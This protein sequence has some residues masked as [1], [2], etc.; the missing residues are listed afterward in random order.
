MTTVLSKVR[1]LRAHDY[2]V[3]L[4]N[5]KVKA[6]FEGRYMV[7]DP[8]DSIDEGYAIVGNNLKEIVIEAHDHLLWAVTNG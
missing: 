8:L 1:E 5:P 7:F 4:R 6:E 2:F 3:G